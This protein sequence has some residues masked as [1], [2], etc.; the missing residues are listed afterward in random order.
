M[1]F[2]D[3]RPSTVVRNGDGYLCTVLSVT[4]S[5]TPLN[6]GEQ[7]VTFV[8]IDHVGTIEET[9]PHDLDLSVVGWTVVHS[10]P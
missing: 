3:L 9:V 7:G 4:P 5:K 1:K 6:R 10:D 8:V 2:G